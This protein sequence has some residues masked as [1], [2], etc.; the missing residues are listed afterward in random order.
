MCCCIQSKQGRG[1][2]FPPPEFLFNNQF[3]VVDL[4]SNHSYL[5]LYPTKL[6]GFHNVG[7]DLFKFISKCNTTVTNIN[8]D[9]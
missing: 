4:P 1:V 8:W 7:V 6:Q 9:L 2:V 5:N 3:P